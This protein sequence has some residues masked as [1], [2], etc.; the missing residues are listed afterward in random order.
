[1]RLDFPLPFLPG[2]DKAS[3]IRGNR[4]LPDFSEYDFRENPNDGEVGRV[5]AN[6]PGTASNAPST[7]SRSKSGTAGRSEVVKNGEPSTDVSNL[8]KG[9][10]SGAG[11][12]CD[13]RSSE[14]RVRGE[15]GEVPANI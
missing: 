5:T 8:L 2:D 13:C 3:Q 9:G 15:K 14:R 6:A 10:V 4:P 1:M 7:T 12:G 11:V